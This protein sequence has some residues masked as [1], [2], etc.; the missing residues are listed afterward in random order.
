MTPLRVA[1]SSAAVLHC[2]SYYRPHTGQSARCFCWCPS[3]C[4]GPPATLQRSNLR[5]TARRLEE[6][7]SK[8]PSQFCLSEEGTSGDGSTFRADPSAGSGIAR[9]GAAVDP[10]LAARLQRV[11]DTFEQCSSSAATL[12][13][14]VRSHEQLVAAAEAEDAIRMLTAQQASLASASSGR[15][16]MDATDA[17]LASALS[18]DPSAAGEGVFSEQSTPTAEA[19]SLRRD[20]QSER[21]QRLTMVAKLQRL[22]LEKRTH[23]EEISE[24]S[25]LLTSARRDTEAAR[26]ALAEQELQA[27]QVQG[28]VESLQVE[29]AVSGG[30]GG[31][32]A[33]RRVS[34][35]RHCSTA[36]SSLRCR[37]VVYNTSIVWWMH[38][39][40]QLTPGATHVVM[41]LQAARSQLRAAEEERQKRPAAVPGN[42]EM[43]SRCG[44][45][46]LRAVHSHCLRCIDA[47]P[48][49][50]WCTRSR[51]TCLIT[52]KLPLHVLQYP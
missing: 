4:V 46:G 31:L 20:L 26:A 30:A 44:W 21:E 41:C 36:P 35:C 14:Q 7:E 52:C 40:A 18:A 23:V 38:S 43:L 47:Q 34:C 29:L 25:V 3:L 6:L 42:M 39:R 33:A 15:Y 50:A 2:T 16:S 24:L 28:A 12:A 10:D 19:R 11:L 45:G 49:T 22:E 37:Q 17:E 8:R 32:H 1:P 5:A 51:G 48:G 13:Q 27:R 9:Q